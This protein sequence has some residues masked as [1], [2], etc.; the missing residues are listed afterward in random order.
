[1]TFTPKAKPMGDAPGLGRK[2]ALTDQLFTW[3]TNLRQFPIESLISIFGDRK[4]HFGTQRINTVEGLESALNSKQPLGDYVLNING[5][6]GSTITLDANNVGAEKL[7]TSATAVNEHERRFDHTKFL[8]DEDLNSAVANFQTQIESRQPLGNYVT[9]VNGLQGTSILLT[10]SD[11]GAE[12]A[13]ASGSAVNFHEQQFNHFNFLTNDSLN[14]AITELETLINTKQQSGNYVLSINGKT[15][16]SI[17]LDASSIGAEPIGSSATAISSHETRFNHSNFLT[18]E[19]LTSA[20]AELTRLINTK[21]NTGDY[22]LSVNGKTGSSIGL[23]P[24]D[25][26][27]ET[28]GAVNDHETRFDHNLFV[29]TSILTTAVNDL[30][31][32]INTKQPMGEYVLSVNGKTGAAIS[33]SPPDIGAEPVGSSIAAVNDHE[34]R[35]DHSKFA[36]TT[37]LRATIT[38]YY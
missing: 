7:G 21:Q 35:F 28:F 33:L 32:S 26:G 4:L 17:T 25:I 8:V 27:A 14:N 24:S 34:T 15:G 18:N 19:S 36:V 9:S 16:E 10:P 38:C 11:I 1:M 20:V 3:T 22:I 13:G 37:H 29:T 31:R 30:N 6:T 5:K 2:P 12:T 23:S